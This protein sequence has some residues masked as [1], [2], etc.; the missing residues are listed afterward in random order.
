MT[1]IKSDICL[2]EENKLSYK[3]W[4]PDMQEFYNTYIDLMW[5]K[6]K[7][8]YFLPVKPIIYLKLLNIFSCSVQHITW[9]E[10]NSI[11]E[12]NL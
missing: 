3:G 7:P 2:T 9:V 6:N 4:E 5:M 1:Q 12:F 10:R 11:E 8:T